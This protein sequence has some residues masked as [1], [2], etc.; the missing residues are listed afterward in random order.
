MDYV[1]LDNERE[2]F[3]RMVF[4]DNGGGVGDNKEWLYTKKW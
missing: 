2:R 3:C 4:K 1:N